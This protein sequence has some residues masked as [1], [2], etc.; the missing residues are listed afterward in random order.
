MVAQPLDA[1]TTTA[2]TATPVLPYADPVTQSDVKVVREPGVVRIMVPPS[3]R[4]RLRDRRLLLPLFYISELFFGLILL[5]V[6][7]GLSGHG[8]LLVLR[9]VTRA[10]VVIL[11]TLSTYDQLRR[12]MVVEITATG[13]SLR[14]RGSLFGRLRRGQIWPHN[15]IREVKISNITGHLIIRVAGQ[16]MREYDLGPNAAANAYVADEINAALA[17]PPAASE[18]VAIDPEIAPLP[19]RPMDTPLR[20]RLRA[21]MQNV[22]AGLVVVGVVLLALGHWFSVAGAVALLVS[23]AIAGITLSPPHAQARP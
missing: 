22:A 14:Y 15:A 4:G 17:S 13:M 18:P 3:L 20:M 2:A 7:G 5:I 11:V 9:F 16:D 10:P 19:V 12:W 21:A 8:W 1:A 23:A 6:M